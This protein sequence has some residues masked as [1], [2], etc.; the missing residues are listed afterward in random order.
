MFLSFPFRYEQRHDKTIKTNIIS[1]PYCDVRS[2][3]AG[4]ESVQ[5]QFDSKAEKKFQLGFTVKN[6]QEPCHI[7][8]IAEIISHCHQIP[9]EQVAQVCYTNT[10][11]LFFNDNKSQQT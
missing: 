7:I 3:H 4:Y 5:T 2:T 8:Q 10:C 6:R 1:C 11:K 9:I